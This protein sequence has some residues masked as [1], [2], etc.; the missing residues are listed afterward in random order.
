MGVRD[1]V[2]V[3]ISHCE[4]RQRLLSPTLDR[5]KLVDPQIVSMYYKF[6]EGA[7]EGNAVR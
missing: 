3:K 7:D 2:E 1:S 5:R 4:G 6:T